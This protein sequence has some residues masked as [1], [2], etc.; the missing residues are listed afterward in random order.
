[1]KKF[2]CLFMTFLFSA[3]LMAEQSMLDRLIVEISGKSYSQKQLEVYVLLRTIAMGEGVKRGLPSAETWA[4]H[5][6][7]FK[8]DMIVYTQLENDQQK[9]DSFVPDFKNVA[10][11]EKALVSAQA[12]DPALDAFI[13]QRQLTEAEISRI[14]TILFR[15]EAYTK[16]RLQ[17]SALKTNEESSF[18]SIDPKTDWFVAL[19]KATSYRYYAHAKDY[20]TLTPFRS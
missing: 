13:R 10:T 8:N 19:S 18:I 17:L 14:L 3:A 1:M 7:N 6:E 5:V 11:A 4:E 12:K 15:V 9:L 2:M 16:N 20:K